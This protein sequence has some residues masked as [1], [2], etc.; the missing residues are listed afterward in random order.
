MTRKSYTRRPPKRDETAGCIRLLRQAGG[1]SLRDLYF[2]G[3]C[4]VKLLKILDPRRELLDR[5][6]PR[7]TSR[8]K[9]GILV[10]SY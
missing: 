3:S 6:N 2:S 5:N 1:I 10:A 4:L 8:H 7:T 9:L